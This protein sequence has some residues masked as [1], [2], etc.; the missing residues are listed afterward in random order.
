MNIGFA[1]T[2]LVIATVSLLLLGLPVAFALG[3]AGLYGIFSTTGTAAWVTLTSGAALHHLSHFGFLAI[4]LFVL[5]SVFITQ[6]GIGARLIDATSKWFNFLPGYLHS[7]SVIACGVF[8]AMSGSSIATAA[9]VGGVVLPEMKARGHSMRLGMGAV[10]AG[11]TLGML[12]PPSNH[13]ILY[14]VLTETSISKLFAAGMVPGVLLVVAFVT[15]NVIVFHMRPDLAPEGETA[16]KVTW[17]DRWIS[18]RR[19]WTAAILIVTV[20]GG[21]FLG[22]VTP[23]EAAG[24][25]ALAALIIGVLLTRTLSLESAWGA[26]LQA[27]QITAMLGMI[28]L[29][30]LILGR[31]MALMNISGAIVKWIS[32]SGFSPWQVMLLINLLLLVLGLLM[33]AAA[34]T[35]ITVPLLFPVVQSLGFD[36]IWFGVVFCINME[37]ALITPPV[38]INLFVIRSITGEPMKEIILGVLPYTAILALGLIVVMVFPGLTLWL[39]SMM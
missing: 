32:E 10:A 12:I 30:G 16:G 20:I 36:P 29:G 4:P 11:G 17:A 22:V 31:G 35:L 24:L 23:T 13:F 38:G 5:M 2:F 6:S 34:I 1:G 21:T 8:S 27:V 15:F 14:G 28:I 19:I 7:A 3:I 37:L 33:D 9:A 18:L 39:P 25:G 26:A